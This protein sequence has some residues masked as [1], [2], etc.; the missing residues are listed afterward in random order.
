[1]STTPRNREGTVEE[2]ET[3]SGLCRAS[4]DVH[5][6][7]DFSKGSHRHFPNSAYL[8]LDK[9]ILIRSLLLKNHNALLYAFFIT[10]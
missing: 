1:M 10:A 3:R 7:D 2:K 5:E 9:P 4:C 6:L 8:H